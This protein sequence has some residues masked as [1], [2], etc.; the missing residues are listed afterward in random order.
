VQILLEHKI[1]A[2][3]RE[4][5]PSGRGPGLS[6]MPLSNRDA[7]GELAGIA[8]SAQPEQSAAIQLRGRYCDR[9]YP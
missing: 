1:T 4:A 6:G 3:F 2:I 8:I 5:P 7:R 9:G